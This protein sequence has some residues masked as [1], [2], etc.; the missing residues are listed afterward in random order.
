MLI[1]NINDIAQELKRLQLSSTGIEHEKEKKRTKVVKLRR[2]LDRD[3][4]M[5]QEIQQ[6][7]SSFT[8][9]SEVLRQIRPHEARDSN[10]NKIH[11]NDVVEIK[12]Y[13]TPFKRNLTK[14]R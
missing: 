12:N 2:S 6:L 3:N 5:L 1:E 11:I 8:A 9:R 7:K 4:V 13:Y 14:S 10:S